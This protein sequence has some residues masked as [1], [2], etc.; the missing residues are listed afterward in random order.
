MKLRRKY[1]LRWSSFLYVGVMAFLGIGAVQTSPLL[2]PL[3]F[4]VALSALL[5]S[6]LIGGA[7]MMGL[8]FR[9]SLLRPAQVGVPVRMRYELRSRAR[10]LPSFSIQI[11]E[12]SGPGADGWERLFSTE[13]GHGRAFVAQIGPRERVVATGVLKPIRRGVCT[14]KGVEVS[15]GFP[16]G[17]FHK[18]VVSDQGGRLLVRPRVRRLR[19]GA[20]PE[21]LR[22]SGAE[23]ATARRKRTGDEFFALR[24]Y[25]PGDSPRFV[26]W[27]ASAR[28]GTLVVRQ[29]AERKAARVRLALVLAG[30]EG[31]SAERAIELFASL[32]HA[33]SGAG[34]ALS[35]DIP[36]ADVMIPERRWNQGAMLEHTL[37]TLASLDVG[38]P[39]L[40][41]ALTP[42]DSTAVVITDGG[43]PGG[44]ASDALMLSHD[45]L[46]R[47]T[48]IDDA[49][50]GAAP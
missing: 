38:S 7:M 4:G 43:R 20:I 47:L 18:S 8:R 6:G 3:V 39:A 19:P 27:H 29:H 21:L 17:L 44:I 22:G 1:K 28:T 15:S 13:G 35:V 49:P 11:A 26:A 42:A 37:D 33:L 10:F 32:A 25:A 50:N 41:S 5:V 9:R 46:D 40:R 12:L 36:H 16:F 48:L 45:D 2:L 30:R 23:S 31:A 24:E 14:L 34:V